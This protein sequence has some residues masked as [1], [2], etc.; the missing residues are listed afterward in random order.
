MP[1]MLHTPGELAGT[2]HRWARPRM[3][4]AVT[5]LRLSLTDSEADKPPARRFLPHLLTA[6]AVMLGWKSNRGF[7]ID[8]LS[9]MAR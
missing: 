9:T 5:T 2:P 8:A 6:R 7:W 1:A 4:T 3:I